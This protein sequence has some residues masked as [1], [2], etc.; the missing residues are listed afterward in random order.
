VCVCVCVL[1][2]RIQLLQTDHMLTET[3][4]KAA[5]RKLH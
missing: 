3:T 4:W 2:T 1:N 5:I